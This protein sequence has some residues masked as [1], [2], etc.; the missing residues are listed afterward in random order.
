MLA[1]GRLAM[2]AA[3]PP[4]R[5][6]RAL[7]VAL[8]GCLLYAAFAGGGTELA[9]ESRVQIA[10]ALLAGV[11]AAVWLYGRGLALAA[12]PLAWT[13]AGL[14]AA[15]ALWSGLSIAWSVAP[16]RS[17]AE[18]NRGLAYALAA[19]L[20]IGA[21]A[22]LP[23]ASGLARACTAFTVLGG[24][25]ALYALAGKTVPALPLPFADLD[26]AGEITRLRA[27]FGY[28]NAL[29]LFCVLS[30]MP[31]LAV[32]LD[33]RRSLR[34]RLLGAG[35]LAV[36]LL[37]L[38][39]TY[40][41]GGLI[42]LAS[43]L[44]AVL[45]LGAAAARTLAWA[46]AA[47]AAMVPAAAVALSSADLT[48][49]GAPLAERTDDAAVVGVLLLAGLGL[50]ALVAK[51]LVG[52]ERRGALA[53]RADRLALRGLLGAAAVAAA[54]VVAGAALSE[55]GLAG[56][57]EAAG[58][59]FT[60]IRSD[61]ATDPARLLSTTSGNRWVWWKE[62]AGAWSDRPVA[63]WGAGSFPVTH[64]LYRTQPLAVA[65]PHSM[66]L[67]WLSE[68]GLV[69]FLLAAGGLLALLAA[70]LARVRAIARGPERVAGAAL[71]AG[72]VAWLVHALY[73]WDWDIPGATLPMLVA[74]GI[75][76]GRSPRP[77]PRP[78][79]RSAG[80][81]AGR[82]LGLAAAVLVLFAAAVSAAL[83]A[84]AQSRAEAALD[85]AALGGPDRERLAGAARDAELAARLDPLSVAPLFA[86][87]TVAERLGDLGQA[88]RQI[89]RAIERQP[90]SAAAWS[91]L[92]RLEIATGNR[93]ALARAARRLLELDPVSPEAI[94]LARRAQG[95][96]MPP[97]G[98]PA[99]TGSPLPIAPAR[100]P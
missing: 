10:L 88:R 48:A 4:S 70:A 81:G 39:L 6:P 46:V 93:P 14:L 9:D 41:R 75:A 63:G 42:A 33:E 52:L 69:G 54:V 95:A 12:S 30:A 37:V 59:R 92:V 53:G 73:D 71:A 77:R 57:A 3:A 18:L 17:W 72:G 32:A 66:P 68:T 26:H 84:L 15:F 8:T 61:D 16:D 86:L 96:L 74:V 21:G 23:R 38:S 67:Q 58:E 100:L 44:I 43:A 11:A 28:W 79:V 94:A 27:P 19:V 24:L 49:D 62:A 89:V 45:A 78:P 98:S 55:R 51:G 60:S 1:S 91:R 85:A 29:G 56:S 35:A 99:A 7:L 5:A 65:Q 31:A 40:S 22:S 82:A 34:G 47:V 36:A 2:A 64:G 83:P 90:E 97:E 80:D 87:A 13:G 76:A 50:L 25:V 20:G